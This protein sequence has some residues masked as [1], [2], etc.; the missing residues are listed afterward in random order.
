MLRPKGPSNCSFINKSSVLTWLISP[1]FEEMKRRIVIKLRGIH[2]QTSQIRSKQS[3]KKKLKILP[4]MRNDVTTLSKLKTILSN[5]MWKEFLDPIFLFLINAINNKWRNQQTIR[6]VKLGSKKWIKTLKWRWKMGPN[7]WTLVAVSSIQI[8]MKLAKRIS[9][10]THSQ[11]WNQELWTITWRWTTMQARSK[12]TTRN[13]R[14]NSKQESKTSSMK[15]FISYKASA[16]IVFKGPC[17]MS[18]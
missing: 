1:L 5:K 10:R 16:G 8:K 12:S 14:Y 6:C 9:E 3:L 11:S 13:S 15:W 17:W 4:K 2:K 18:I 7:R